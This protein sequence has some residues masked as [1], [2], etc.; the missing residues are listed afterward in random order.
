LAAGAL[1]GATLTAPTGTASSA[2]HATASGAFVGVTMT[3]PT[4]T[5]TGSAQ[6]FASFMAAVLT[7]PAGAASNGD[8]PVVDH[9]IQVY[10]GKK[11][12]GPVDDLTADD[13]RKHWDYL[14]E[15]T[16]RDSRAPV[17]KPS[18]DPEQHIVVPD[19]KAPA[20]AQAFP[21]PA[22]ATSGMSTSVT[23]PKAAS[24]TTITS[25]A[26]QERAELDALI[27]SARRTAEDALILSLLNS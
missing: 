25:A 2:G 14:E 7:A 8:L 26:A 21:T 20:P 5:A 16:A 24:A 13:V 17:A 6:A 19:A 3:A 11:R 10:G 15:R 4:A 18:A 27:R 12:Q 1:A 9:Q 22:A 23:N